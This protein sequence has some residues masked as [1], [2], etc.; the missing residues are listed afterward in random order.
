MLN[1]FFGMLSMARKIGL[2]WLEFG[3]NVGAHWPVLRAQALYST[4][5]PTRQKRRVPQHPRTWEGAT[6]NNFR[7][8]LRRSL[9]ASLG[10]Q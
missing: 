7:T 1:T 2:T 10:G 3:N 8:N 5:L 9:P 4:T 6:R